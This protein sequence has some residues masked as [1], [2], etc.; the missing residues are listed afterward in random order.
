MQTNNKKVAL[1]LCVVLTVGVLP[2]TW[3]GCASTPTRESSGEYVDDAAIT[4]KVK[5]ALVKD[6]IVSALDVHVKTYKGMVQ[7]S[8]FVD[9]ADQKALAE[10]VARS[11]AGVNSVKN[12]LL[13]KGQ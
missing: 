6:P 8:G 13:V 1:M 10:N 7:L 12:G 9:S 4:T 2:A 11:V 5:A 3:M